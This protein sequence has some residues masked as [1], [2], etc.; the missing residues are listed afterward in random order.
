MLVVAGPVHVHQ[1]WTGRQ[2][3]SH[4]RQVSGLYGIGE[5]CDGCAI[6]KGLELRPTRES[7]GA[8]QHELRIVESKVRRIGVALELTYFSNSS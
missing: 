8:S 5:A 1:F 3:A 4:L 2:H 6:D 7:I